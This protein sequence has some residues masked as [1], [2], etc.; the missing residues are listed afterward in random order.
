VV[1]PLG[2]NATEI[3]EFWLGSVRERVRTAGE[4]RFQR[5]T[6][7]PLPV[8]TIALLGLKATEP[9]ARVFTGFREVGDP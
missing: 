8:A 7:V 9:P 2:L 4:V 5:K 3:T 1:V 6:A